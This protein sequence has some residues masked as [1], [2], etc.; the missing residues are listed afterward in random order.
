M[1]FMLWCALGTLL[2][3]PV[4]VEAVVG[5]APAAP[6]EPD[7]AVVFVQKYG[8]SARLEGIK[9]DK[10]G[11]YSFMGIKYA[12][13]P[14]G[15]RRFQ[16]PVRRM[17]TGD[18]NATRYCPPCIQPDTRNPGRIIGQEDCLCLNV[19]SPKMPGEEE[20]SPVIFYIHGGNYRTGS[21]SAYG[22]QHLA[23]K[24]TIIVSAQYRLGSLGYLSTGER[25][26]SGN[27]GLFDLRSAMAWINDYIEFFGGDK[28]R[29]VVMGQ[30]SGGSAASLMAMSSEGRA[31]TG[32]IALSGTPLSPGAVR[33]DPAS[34]AK[35][36]AKETNCPESP[37][38]RLILCLRSIPA[39][40]IVLADS[41]ISMSMVDTEKF[42]QDISG[43]S[44]AGARVEG[45][46][47]LRGL[48]PIVEEQPAD[49]LNKKT[50][51]VPMLTG[52]VSAETAR[53][54]Q[55]KYAG[56]LTNKLNDLNFIKNELIGGLRGVVSDVRGLI[57]DLTSQ[58]P[59]GL[60]QLDYYHTLFDSTFNVVDGLIQIAE[61]T[62]DALFNFPA[63]QSVKQWS[64][65]GGHAYLYSFEHVGNLSKGSHFLPGVALAE[66][67][68]NTRNK[69]ETT[70]KM[71]P[72]PSHGDELA[73]IFEP[74]DENGKSITGEVSASDARARENF[75]NIISKFAH[76]L[77]P[78]D[79][80][81]DSRRPGLAGFLPFSEGNEQFLKINEDVTIDKDFRY[82]QMGLWGN[83][84]D[85][86]TG[87]LCKNLIGNLLN[88]HSIV[89]PD[90]KLPI[91][92]PTNVPNPLGGLGNNG[93]N[94]LGGLGKPGGN[95]LGGLGGLG[96]LVGGNMGQSQRQTAQKPKT[97]TQKPS[98]NFPNLPFRF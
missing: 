37:P 33:T 14:V 47:D 77:T 52:V 73:Y 6:P 55:G 32:V 39:E 82:C 79:A 80:K 21:T 60:P 29:I 23:Q 50:K 41:E 35:A 93:G 11:Y 46:E 16:R 19:F 30:G 4:V 17:L 65:G 54:V 67:D 61:A 90:I 44:G 92:V 53:A 62:G 45:K 13:P 5:G 9:N 28:K 72:G 2:S 97:T 68:S 66:D 74:L 51:R 84:A 40:K 85:R 86:L 87:A 69:R 38:E 56:F 10:L 34:H 8:R 15:P 70:S 1:L 88:L 63:Y 42:L 91:Q 43:R 78:V 22:G 89:T 49:A 83:M 27:A 76:Q 31:A 98:M 57:P 95:A 24:D 18:V 94:A 75:V 71:K 26:A 20:G 3:S 7:S 59:A 64:Q 48:P 12:E 81:N 25:D 96:G 58:L 36:L